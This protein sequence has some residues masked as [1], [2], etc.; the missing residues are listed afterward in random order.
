MTHKDIKTKF[1]IEYDK[2]NVTSSY[3]SL[4][5]YEIAT[6]LDK[7]YNALIAQKFTGNNARSVAFEGDIKSMQD[8]SPLITTKRLFLDQTESRDFSDE[9]DIK[10]VEGSN[11]KIDVKTNKSDNIFPQ[12]KK[13]NIL[14]GDGNVQVYKKFRMRSMPDNMRRAIL[15]KDLMYFI[16]AAT[17]VDITKFAWW[18][19][20]E[21]NPYKSVN[22]EPTNDVIK[23]MD[24]KDEDY[25]DN[26]YKSL[27]MI[28]IKLVTHQMAEQFFATSS[29][30][31]WVKEPV[32]YIQDGKLFIIA[33]PIVGLADTWFTETAV[34][35][36]SVNG[37]KGMDV[38]GNMVYGEYAAVTYIKQPAPFTLENETTDFTSDFELSNTMADE[39]V[40]LAVTYALENV[41]STRLNTQIQMRG[42]ES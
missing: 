23:P 15:P 22:E 6:I 21:E 1:L 42:L 5:D 30:I 18:M 19:N 9:V 3:P 8:L 41:E 31:P 12:T 2:A 25:N 37:D 29:N 17:I 32:G 40:T 36:K 20:E 11:S 24:N 28:P 39:L 7:A 14:E 34:N 27:R 38:N 26:K 16:S 33:D 35:P 10:V 4:T 13:H